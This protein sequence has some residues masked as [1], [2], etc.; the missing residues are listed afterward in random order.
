MPALGTVSSSQT[1]DLASREATNREAPEGTRQLW[2]KFHFSPSSLELA[3]CYHLL[4]QPHGTSGQSWSLERQKA[5]SSGAA[6]LNI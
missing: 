6:G 1:S 3:Q 4:H 5:D 2:V